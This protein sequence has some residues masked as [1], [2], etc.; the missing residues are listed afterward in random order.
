MIKNPEEAKKAFCEVSILRRQENA[1]FHALYV[2]QSQ[3]D[4]CMY[5]SSRRW[6]RFYYAPNAHSLMKSFSEI[7]DSEEE[8]KNDMHLFH[9]IIRVGILSFR[10]CNFSGITAYY[11]GERP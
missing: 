3:I 4:E 2:Y 1:V 9:I 7:N 6:N 8:Q 11:G 5:E 10:L